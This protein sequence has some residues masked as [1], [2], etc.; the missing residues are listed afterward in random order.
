MQVLN[1]ALFGRLTRHFGTPIVQN[2]GQAMIARPTKDLGGRV[3]LYFVQDGEYYRIRC[4]YCQDYKPRL[5]VNHMFGKKDAT[6]RTMNF[7]A[8]CFNENCL[9]DPNNLED[10]KETLEEIGTSLQDLK[11]NKGQVLPEEARTVL[12]PGACT[13][14]SKLKKDHPARL[15]LQGRGFDPDYLAKRFEIG[16]C[17]DSHWFLAKRRI[18]IPI[19]ER[20]LLKGWQARYV[21]ELP[22]KHKDRSKRKELPPKYFSCPNSR[23]R[24]MCIYNWD[25]AIEWE[26]I[27]IVE[28]PS[29]AWRFGP[30][31]GCIFGN[32]LTLQQ[33]KKLRAR[34]RGR[35]IVLL[36]DPEEYESKSTQRTIAEF[37]KL[38]G[39]RFCAVKL[40]TGTDP[41]SLNRDVLRAYVKAEAKKQGVIVR[42]RKLRTA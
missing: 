14:L 31:A 28:G 6:G 19:Y 17:T 34:K 40:P 8:L 7:L 11:V 29:D 41:G 18:I 33:K 2:E 25:K 13:L 20:G 36:L 12:L 21:G 39:D 32:S 35:T 30:M 38:M 5:Y 10:F 37:K 3:R 23:F 1:P 27:V 4:P 15:Y 24:S 9:L 22:W 16:Y 42:Y 26:T